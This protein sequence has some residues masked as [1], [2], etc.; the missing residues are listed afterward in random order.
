MREQIWSDVAVLQVLGICIQYSAPPIPSEN[1][2]SD[3]ASS[4]AIP[5]PR[6]LRPPDL[7]LQLKDAIQ[8]RLS[9]RR[10]PR[11]INI[12]RNNAVDSSQDTVAVVIVASAVGAAAHADHPLGIWHLVVEE[13]DRRRHLV[14]DGAG[15][16]HHVGL[17]W[18]CA[19]DDAQAVLVV[20]RH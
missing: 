18:G 15:D 7:I 5:H 8:Q 12:H 14:A 4:L 20:A 6:N 11:N 16:D 17:A 9:C 1:R 10:T 19:E 3:P 2:E 13:S